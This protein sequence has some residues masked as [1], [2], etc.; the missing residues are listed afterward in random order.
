MSTQARYIVH[1]SS[2]PE[3]KEEWEKVYKDIQRSV[4]AAVEQVEA[5]WVRAPISPYDSVYTGLTGLALMQYHIASVSHTVLHPRSPAL[6]REATPTT[7]DSK[8]AYQMPL[9]PLR[10]RREADINLY[11]V[12]HQT[13][14]PRAVQDGAHAS[15][16]ETAVGRAVLVVARCLQLE[17]SL[18][19]MVGESEAD[20]RALRRL[21]R[22]WDASVRLLWDALGRVGV[23]DGVGDEGDGGSEVLYGRAGFLY[24]LLYLRK[25]L[26]GLEVGPGEE[27]SEERR[28]V[29]RELTGDGNLTR[30]ADVIVQRGR[31]GAR[32]YAKEVGEDRAPPL[33]WRWHGKAYLGGAHGVF[34]ILQMLLSCPEAVIQKH[35]PDILTEVDWIL[36]CQESQGNWSGKAPGHKPSVGSSDLVQWC[37]GA[38]GAIILLSTVLSRACS[39]NLYYTLQRDLV[40]RIQFAI[41]KAADLVYTQG[42]LRKGLG[43]CHGVSGSVY[44]LLSA[45]SALSIH[46]TALG[47]PLKFDLG[48]ADADSGYLKKAVHLA[49]LAIRAGQLTEAG[50]MRVPDRPWSLYEGI[51]GM[52]C[53]WV[54]VLG[55]LAEPEEGEGGGA[56][57]GRASGMPGYDDLL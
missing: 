38:P 6:D 28:Q 3:G 9:D 25:A 1:S 32:R 30:V 18:A 33:M 34:G 14:I 55:R 35:I 57:C 15:F 43:L 51:A 7:G 23:E 37:H 26:E 11:T 12:V 40:T 50:E 53:A 29:V 49:H 39:P 2:P 22:H 20:V 24:G 8:A 45:S 44:A 56:S 4:V 16:I 54:N 52:C 47:K 10:L 31:V 5:A 27:S 46:Y 17:A 48:A 42:L 36:A 13:R 19:D 41:Q 21:G